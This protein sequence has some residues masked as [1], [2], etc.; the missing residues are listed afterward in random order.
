[1]TEPRPPARAVAL[2]E[3]EPELARLA[4]A[5]QAAREG[6]GRLLV[7][8]GPAGIGKS[9]VLEAACVA[10]REQGCLVLDAVAGEFERD[11][12]FGVVRR[13]FEPMLR[14]VSARD[15]RRQFAGAAALAR[16]LLLP[17][18]RTAE[19]QAEQASVLHG[20]YWLA[21]N[22][23]DQQP[24]VLCVDDV[25][26][27]DP[28]SLAWLLYLAR[29][30][31]DLPVFVL[32][33]VRSGEAQRQGGTLAALVESALDRRITLAP[34]SEQATGELVRQ[35]W[36]KA[37]DEVCRACFEVTRGNPFLLSELLR[38]I[39]AEKPSDGPALAERVCRLTPDAVSRSVIARLRRLP[40]E[41]AAVAYALAVMG[42]RAD[43]RELLA[44]AELEAEPGLRAIDALEQEQIAAGR[45]VQFIHPLVATAIYGELSPA[46]RSLQH[47]RAAR[48]L[49]GAGADASRVASHVLHSEP[50]GDRWAV[51]VLRQAAADATRDGSP[52]TA[53]RWLNRALVEPPTAADRPLVLHELGAAELRAGPP[54]NGA[55]SA[56]ESH[57]A[58][59]VRTAAEPRA[60]AL[61][62]IDWGD[63]LWAAHRYR[64]AVQAFA[65]GIDAVRDHDGELALR[66]E[67]HLAAAGR[68]D[69]ETCRLVSRRL[70]QVREPPATAGGRLIAGVLAV[71]RALAGQPAGA[72]I[73]L[74]ERML[75]GGSL[76][77]GQIAAQIP[78][79]A[80]N[81]LLWCDRFEQSRRLLDEMISGG[82]TNGSV[83]TVLIAFCWRGLVSHRTGALS[84]AIGDLATAVELAAE[85]GSSSPVVT[86]SFLAEALLDAGDVAGASDT[87]AAIT[88]PTV[89]PGYIGWNYFLYARGMLHAA[90]L[91]LREAIDDFLACGVRQEQWEAPNPSV[92][93]WRS[94]AA[95]AY[96][97]LGHDA[98]A[99]DLASAELD[100]ARR[101]GAPRAVGIAL[102]ALGLCDTGKRQRPRLQDAV[103]VLEGSPARL[104]RARALTDLGS[105]LRR[106][107][108]RA[109][110]R[111][112]LHRALEIATDCG[113]TPLVERARKE[114]L[115]TGARPRKVPRTGVDA[116]TPVE[117]QA[118]T[119]AAQGL[120]NPQIA[121]LLFISRKTVEKRLGDAYRKLNIHT[122]EAL[123]TAL[124]TSSAAPAGAAAREATQP[125]HIGS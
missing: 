43:P 15:L 96:H 118:A 82:R 106:A 107:N 63:A 77:S 37:D 32:L 100:L 4:S 26:W 38:A 97:A 20:L 111:E 46:R 34:L 62:A 10:G 123:T 76:P 104:E 12:S 92:I 54:A 84:E 48:M 121:Q 21:A 66:I 90:R 113:A 52:Q 50:A 81:A 59:A 94:Q 3:R 14:G 125:A 108:Q 115:A 29:R 41:A 5:L 89:L 109:A 56:A 74:A 99:R 11:M 122:R 35:R 60:R 49:A 36:T 73:A 79:F 58:E 24:L 13:I 83:R 68:L 95:L 112:P 69:L 124:A 93:P 80:T 88:P 42:G 102:R 85:H 78:L 101:F 22:L 86:Q 105:S 45:P 7:V 30:L 53:A 117:R 57:L 8:E 27:C 25:Q 31:S 120:S 23:S 19:H 65:R 17:S 110:A 9:S 87:I 119:M 47:A 71:D 6:S 18:A 40:G 1:M 55:E 70:E 64:D 98:P 28:A 67:A 2:A 103:A 16:P 91:D 61:A 33:A 114:L 75:A 72:V 39:D 44:L 51:D 116:L